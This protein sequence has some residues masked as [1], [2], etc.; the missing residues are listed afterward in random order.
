M[1]SL[2]P[3][4]NKA[5]EDPNEFENCHGQARITLMRIAVDKIIDKTE[6]QSKA[7]EYVVQGAKI[8]YEIKETISS[9]L[10]SYPP[11][12]LAFSG[13]CATLPVRSILSITEGV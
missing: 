6:K 11:A 1:E 3:S 4:E 5:H 9:A 8:L 7:R 2:A 13:L 12:A 10:T